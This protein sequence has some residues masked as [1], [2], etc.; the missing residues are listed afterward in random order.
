MFSSPEISI[1]VPCYNEESFLPR[2]LQALKESLAQLDVSSEIIVVDNNSSDNSATVAECF[3]AKVVFEPINQISRA[4]NAGARAAKGKYLFF[5]DAD[6]VVP[7]ELLE[8]AYR[9][10]DEAVACGG[11]ALVGVEK[12]LPRVGQYF[13]RLWNFLAQRRNLAAGCFIYCLREAFEEVGGFSES[14]YASE[15]IWLSRTLR[16]WGRKQHLPFTVITEPKVITSTRKLDWFSPQKMFLGSLVF[17][18]FPFAVR[19]RSLCF[20]W[21]QRPKDRKKNR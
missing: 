11:G 8:K 20:F 3:K 6:T 17:F 10:L 12:Q 7:T 19:Y 16:A 21:Y 5:V 1:I 15:E 18:I 9:N 4:R 14:V 13:Q 2:T